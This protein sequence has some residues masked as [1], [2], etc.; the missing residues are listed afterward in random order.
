MSLKSNLDVLIKKKGVLDS[1]GHKVF[2]SFSVAQIF[3]DFYT[4]V[5][6]KLVSNLPKSYGIFGT[7]TVAFRNFY[8]RRIG[9]R[10]RFVISPVTSHFVL[11]Q[12]RALDPKKSVGLDDISSLF[13]RD[14]ADVITSPVTHIINLSIITETVPSVFKE[15]RVVP[16]FKKGSKLDPGN[17]RPVSLLNVLSKILE[18]AV[19][20]QLSHYLEKRGLLFENQSG[21]R[22]GF[23]TDS[24]L[25][26]IIILFFVNMK[27]DKHINSYQN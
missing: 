26:I 6:S 14:G 23:S 19:H 3:N 16:L 12:L 10:S 18:R 8:S 9:L 11:N 24:C 20:S 21:F 25:I 13:L 15:A 2:D 22:G 4:S 5:A 27:C 7:A 1:D 17:Y